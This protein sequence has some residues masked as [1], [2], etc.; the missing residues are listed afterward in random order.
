MSGGE[1]PLTKVYDQYGGKTS[2]EGCSEGREDGGEVEG[3]C[4]GERG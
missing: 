1:G 3:H 2:E 4:L